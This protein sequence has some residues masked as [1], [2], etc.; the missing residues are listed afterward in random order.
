MNQIVALES[1]R[2]DGLVR[3]PTDLNAAGKSE[4]PNPR[5]NSSR[6]LARLLEGPILVPLLK[7][8]FPTLV[9][10]GVQTFVSVAETYFVSRLGTDALAGVALVFPVL[11]LMTM[12]SNG[13]IGGGV[14]ASVART[15]GSG[16]KQDA[17]AL[18]LHAVVLA[19]AFGF[20]FTLG[21]LG[22]GTAIYRILGGSGN[23][24]DAALRYSTF[25]FGGAVLIWV[26]NLI[27]AA[28]RGA[29]DVTTPALVTLM[30]A[31]IVVPLSP[32]FIF[33]WGPIPSLGIAGAG[34]AVV[35]YYILATAALLLYLGSKRSPLRLSWTPLR[36]HLF[37]DILGVGALSAIGTIQINLTVAI[38]TAFVGGFGTDALAGY[39]IASRVDYLLIPLLFGLG[40]AT[41]TMVGSNIGAGKIVRARRIAWTAAVLAAVILEVIGVLAAVFPQVWIGMFS[42]E[43]YILATGGTYL[44]IVGPLYG[45][46]G[47]GMMLYFAS[48]GAKSV[49]LPVLA[50]TARLFI[51]VIGGWAV[52]NIWSGTLTALF[53][54]VALTSAMFGIL[55]AISVRLPSWGRQR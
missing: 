31:I 32:A 33:G 45:F 19:V 28:L 49:G 36:L 3:M 11:M 51:T 14:S 37:K 38:L 22:G 4:A 1:S 39:G 30:G 52:L 17:D 34:A 42:A 23:T 27:S 26:V 6:N 15:L 25:V 9:V 48:Q 40:T 8:A 2:V 53:S 47:L 24:L 5:P 55:V 44:R 10:L 35:I 50:G 43:P 20:L 46:V 41:V 21:I 13:G 7:L 18:L 29:G 12:M 16:R 54:V